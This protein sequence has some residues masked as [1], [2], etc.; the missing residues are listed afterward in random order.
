MIQGKW[1]VEFGKGPQIKALK[2]VSLNGLKGQQS[3]KKADEEFIYSNLSN[4]SNKI[5]TYLKQFVII[6]DYG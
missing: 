2:P 1:T 6:T 4:Y 5:N 3:P